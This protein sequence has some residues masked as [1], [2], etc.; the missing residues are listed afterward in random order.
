MSHGKKSKRKKHKHPAG[1]KHP[2]GAAKLNTKP[3]HVNVTGK[4]ETD[5][6]PNLVEKYDS[7]SKKENGW[8]RKQFFVSLATAI[9][10]FAYTTIAAWQGCLSK[11]QVEIAQ[12][13]FDA[14]NRPY[15]GT[16]NPIAGR[17]DKQRILTI[18]F[19]LKN[20]GSIP[21]TD[22]LADWRVRVNGQLGPLNYGVEQ[23]PGILFPGAETTMVG[24]VR[25]EVFDAVT[26]GKQ[27]LDI[28]IV[29]EYSGPSGPYEYCV[30]EHYLSNVNSF[31]PTATSGCTFKP[32]KR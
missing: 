10:V 20:F 14:V 7:A 18:N 32:G 4:I 30:K 11:K 27:S 24:D 29:A 19:H 25:N 21:A 2:E 23:G 26:S 22:F 15:V 3:D 16:W 12:R 9:I 31:S 1:H 8:N 17:D 5:F 13:T 28:E 6:P